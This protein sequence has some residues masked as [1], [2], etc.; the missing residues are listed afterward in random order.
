MSNPIP[1]RLGLNLFWHNF[2]YSDTRYSMYAQQDELIQLLSETYLTYGS[3]VKTTLFWHP[4]WFKTTIY[5]TTTYSLKYYRW[6]SIVNKVFHTST[7]YR[8]RL[9]GEQL[10]KARFSLLRFNSW[11]VIN[12]FWFQPNKSHKRRLL[13][14]NIHDSLQTTSQRTLIDNKLRRLR[15]IIYY[16]QLTVTPRRLSYDF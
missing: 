12:L 15:S 5:K 11:V 16:T 1:N 4:Y 9:L 8:F 2:W 6:A 7:N 14:P 3:N 13:M 10:I